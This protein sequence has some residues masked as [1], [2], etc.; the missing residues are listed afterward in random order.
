MA[1]SSEKVAELKQI[2]HN[3]LSQVFYIFCILQFLDDRA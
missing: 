2:V 1:L 3:Y